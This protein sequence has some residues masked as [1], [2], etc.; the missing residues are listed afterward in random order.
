LWKWLQSINSNQFLPADFTVVP[1]G[2]AAHPA[3]AETRRIYSFAERFGVVTDVSTPVKTACRLQSGDMMPTQGAFH[4]L[5]RVS[6]DYGR[7]P[8]WAR[9]VVWRNP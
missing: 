9:P 8:E 7:H 1:P 6:P 2:I 4:I 5:H 3:T